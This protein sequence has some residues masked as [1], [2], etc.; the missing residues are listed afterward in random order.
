[1]GF[2]IYVPFPSSEESARYLMVWMGM[3]GSAVALRHGRHIGVTILAERIPSV[4]APYFNAFI[5]I[6][7][8]GFLVVIARQGLAL[9]LFNALQRSPALRISMFYPYFSIPVGAVFMILELCADLLHQFFP[10]PAGA[11]RTLVSRMLEGTEP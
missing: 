4:C 5:Q 2:V 10:T 3:L 8:I 9:A 1:M 11:Q 7:M 6:V